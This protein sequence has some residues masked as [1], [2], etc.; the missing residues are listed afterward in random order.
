MLRLGALKFSLEDEL[1]ATIEKF[2]RLSGGVSVVS[3]AG[4]AR[5]SL[6][7]AALACVD[8]ASIFFEVEDARSEDSSLVSWVPSGFRYASQ[9]CLELF[10]LGQSLL[11]C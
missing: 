3:H 6:L 2:D 4:L 9:W 1:A 11:V 5:A 8:G 7:P 10:G